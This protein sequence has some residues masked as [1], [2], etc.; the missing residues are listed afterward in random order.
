MIPGALEAL[1]FLRSR[2]IKT[3]GTTGYFEEAAQRV[4]TLAAGQGFRLD[5]NAW[6]QPGQPGRPG[7]ALVR[8]L[9]QRFDV[10]RSET[11][12]KI[13]DT[14]HDVAEGLSAGAWSVAVLRGSSALGLDAQ[15]FDALPEP[16]RREKLQKAGA[17]MLDAG[18]HAVIDS[19]AGVP[20]VVAGI[21]RELARGV[22]KPQRLS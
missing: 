4:E 18:A 1:Q 10:G 8:S 19:L 20:V 7:P 13:G 11:V 15:A 3:G 5:A 22:V 16:L 6:T 2:N 14:V 17:T 9:M 12:L 21:E